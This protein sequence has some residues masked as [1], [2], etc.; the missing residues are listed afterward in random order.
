MIK[1]DGKGTA[2]LANGDVLD[3]CWSNGLLHGFG[4]FRAANGD[5]YTGDWADGDAFDGCQMDLD[6]DLEFIDMQMGMSTWEIG[7]KT[8]WMEK[9]L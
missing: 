9:E 8:K 6:M 2:T 1:K 4:V 3:A 7:K 5:V